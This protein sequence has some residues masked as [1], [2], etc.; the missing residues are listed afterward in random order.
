MSSVL[1]LH[2]PGADQGFFGIVG[3]HPAMLALFDRMQR[4]AVHSLPLLITGE[5]GVGKELVA[6]ALHRLSGAR[7]AMVPLNVAVLSEPLADA[8]LFGTVRGAFTGALDRPGLIEAAAGGTL[9]L[10]EA[11][12]LSLA[13]QARLLRALESHTV[14]RVGAR[15]ERCVRFRLLLSIQRPVSTLLAQGRWREDFCYRVNGLTLHV[16]PLRDRR[17]DIPFLVNYTLQRLGRAALPANALDFLQAHDWPGNVR[18]LIRL[19]ERAVF[20]GG[21][22]PVTTQLLEGELGQSAANGIDARFEPA[23]ASRRSMERATI[24]RVLG[25]VG[26]TKEAA[27]RLDLSVHQLYRR[28]RALGI[29][30][31]RHR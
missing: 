21:E 23:T 16:P 5:T 1:Q 11:S 26:N 19:V 9:F 20:A 2:D 30:P 29:T 27:S 22:E 24:E 12:E 18:E 7:G 10:D 6:Q 4:A 28:F 13:A 3:R 14:R 31:P 8:E 17:S 25:E 15:Q